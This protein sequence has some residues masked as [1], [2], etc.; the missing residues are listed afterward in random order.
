MRPPIA[1]P[2]ER[3]DHRTQSRLR[4]QS[5]QQRALDLSDGCRFAEHRRAEAT[6]VVGHESDGQR[7]PDIRSDVVRVLQA[8]VVQ[9]PREEGGLL[10]HRD[11]GLVGVGASVIREIDGDDVEAFAEAFPP[12]SVGKDAQWVRV[13]QQELRY[14]R[15]AR[16]SEANTPAVD[17]RVLEL[18]TVSSIV[19]VHQLSSQNSAVLPAGNLI[20]STTPRESL[21]LTSTPAASL[22]Y[23]KRTYTRSP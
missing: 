5:E 6:G 17:R 2:A 10:G 9:D 22:L 20:S 11:Q 12:V 19:S 4:F 1:P 7:R 13:D 18:H 3:T 23:D 21:V 15:L 8:E 14:A 16:S